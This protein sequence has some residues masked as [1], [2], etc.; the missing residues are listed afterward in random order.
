MDQ[1]ISPLFLINEPT[2]VIILPAFSKPFSSRFVRVI[3]AN[4]LESV[5]G[6]IVEDGQVAGWDGARVTRKNGI[7]IDRETWRLIDTSTSRQ[8]NKITMNKK[9]LEKFDTFVRIFY[10]CSGFNYATTWPISGWSSI[11]RPSL[12]AHLLSRR[13]TK[14]KNYEELLIKSIVSS[15]PN[16]NIWFRN[17]GFIYI[18]IA[19]FII[20]SPVSGPTRWLPRWCG[21]NYIVS[22]K[23]G[24]RSAP[25]MSD[26][27]RKLA[28]ESF[29]FPSRC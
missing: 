6:W 25:L 4:F 23:A 11:E 22:C 9:L 7:E 27:N 16:D 18:Y 21:F 19:G 26:S 5:S 1:R 24:F 8:I 2:F 15:S 10:T 29:N 20:L 17:Q 12:I 28:G 3:Y 13:I 14:I